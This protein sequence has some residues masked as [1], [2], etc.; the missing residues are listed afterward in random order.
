MKSNIRSD[1]KSDINNEKYATSLLTRLPTY[2]RKLY[3][4]GGS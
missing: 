2:W 1:M 3:G 4:S